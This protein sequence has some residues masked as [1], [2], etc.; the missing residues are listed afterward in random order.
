[1]PVNYTIETNAAPGGGA[2]PATGWNQVVAISGNNRGTMQHPFKLMG[3]NWV[4]MTVNQTSDPAGGL[5]LDLDV[6]S[7]PAGATDSWMM[8]GDSITFSCTTYAYSDLPALVQKVDSARYPAITDAAIAGTSA[9]SAVKIIDDTIKG[10]PGPFIV[11]AYGTNDLADEF[12]ANMET[13]VKKVIA[14][15]RIPVVPH[16]PWSD[17]R[18]DRGP[19]IN[20]SIDALYAKYPE[21]L[22]GPDLWAFFQSHPQ[23][24]SDDHLHPSDAGAEELRKQWAAVMAA[25]P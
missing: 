2:P 1:M 7:T 17:Q 12:P 5:F 20:A 21:I 16:M 4:R 11:L 25:I 10:F 18:L 3:A 15:G 6:F 13:L 19:L 22:R 9:M 14:S 23:L 8:M 24:I